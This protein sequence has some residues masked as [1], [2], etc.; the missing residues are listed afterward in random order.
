MTKPNVTQ[1]VAGVK[2][3]IEVQGDK[4][5]QFFALQPVEG[6]FDGGVEEATKAFDKI[7]T[8]P[9]AKAAF[10][11]NLRKELGVEDL[12]SDNI[13]N[14]GVVQLYLQDVKPNSET[15]DT[16]L[17][18]TAIAFNVAILDLYAD[19]ISEWA[20]KQKIDVK[21]VDYFMEVEIPW[22]AS[23]F[24]GAPA[25]ATPADEPTTAETP[26]AQAPEQIVAEVETPA[27]EG[28]VAEN[29]PAVKQE[30]LPA[31]ADNHK[32]AVKAMVAAGRQRQEA[33]SELAEGMQ[34]I[35]NATTKLVGAQNNDFIAIEA[36]MGI[37]QEALPEA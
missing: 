31:I 22:V 16:V 19:E 18:Y 14:L 23:H 11:A 1:L 27:V 35:A 24:Q 28:P 25:E 34:K 3:F 6:L 8:D 32:V 37:P 29:L 7:F 9:A 15:D 13:T 26:T 30:N 20:T 36:L 10:V 12:T 5:L 17:T 21:K 33:L 4:K 2:T